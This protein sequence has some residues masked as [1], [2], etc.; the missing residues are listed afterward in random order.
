MDENI[1]V[2]SNRNT[3][4]T[5][6]TFGSIANCVRE[7]RVSRSEVRDNVVLDI[8]EGG[9]KF[10]G[11]EGGSLL[12]FTLFDDVQVLQ[13]VLSLEEVDFRKGYTRG[14]I[15]SSVETSKKEA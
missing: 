15:R 11:R 1:V 13:R 10:A 7:A 6:G 12:I 8:W 5:P 2:D 9:V 14:R 3:D 4:S